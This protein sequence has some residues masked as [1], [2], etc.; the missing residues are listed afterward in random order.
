MDGTGKQHETTVLQ[1]ARRVHFNTTTPGGLKA[2]APEKD[3]KMH[4]MRR[5]VQFRDFDYQVWT[6]GSVV[7]D[8]SSGAGA[9]VYRKQGRREKV[10]PG[11]GSVACSYRAECVAMEA[12]LKRLVDVIELNQT[13]RTRVVAF[14]DSLS[15][16]MAL[17]TGPAVVEDA[18][19]RRIWD[20]ILRLVRLRVSVNF[21][22]VFSHG[23]VPRNEAADKAAEQGNAKPQMYP[24]WVTDIVT[25]V[26]RQ[27]RNEMYRSFEE[28]RMLRTHRR[29]LLDHVRPAPKHTKLD[30]LGESLW[31]QF[32][33]GT[34]KHFGWLHRVLTRKTDRLECRWCG[35]QNIG[36]D[37]VEGHTLAKSA[38]DSANA[39][40]FGMATRQS[41]PIIGPLC[42]MVCARRQAGVVHLVKIHGLVRECA[43]AM[44]KKARRA[45]LTYKNGYTCHVCG[46]ALERCG[47]LAEHMAQHPPV[48]ILA[49]EER[50]KRA[51]EED[52]ADGGKAFKCYCFSKRY[53]VCA[54]L[55]KHMIQK[56]PEKQLKSDDI[57]VEKEASSD[58]DGE[59][60]Q[61]EQNFVCQKCDRVLKS[62]TWLT[63]HKC[64]AAANINSEDS[65]VAEQADAAVRPIFSKEYHYKWLL[66][67][68]MEKHP[69][70]DE[71]LRPQPR[72]KP[73]RKTK[74]SEAQAQGGGGET[75]ESVCG[76]DV[77]GERP[78]KRLHTGMH[79]EDEEGRDYVC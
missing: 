36:G 37:A 79:N 43:L 62:K 42:N 64:D 24:A 35:A 52:E 31:V 16:R 10:V 40:N 11:A 50:P 63:R 53:T 68:M 75:V 61:E 38:V 65:N 2:D 18:I 45:A 71:S 72:A 39:P 26:E 46:D 4:T 34:S 67:H 3:K 21:Q 15:L 69:G 66:R 41:D 30:R 76:S 73:K 19:L 74:R 7:L 57:P 12:G 27:V 29:V 8:V 55:R 51:R 32:R 77:D 22:F 54:R 9:L 33:T 56:H 49:E 58:S 44:T 78:R 20:L 17:S 14:T 25:G 47:L 5:V 70:H 23:G 1:L 60:V 59:P 13:L 48:G 28:G 6:D